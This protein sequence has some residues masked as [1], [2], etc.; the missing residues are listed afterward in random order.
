SLLGRWEEA[1]AAWK[2]Y[3]IRYPEHLI[4]HAFLA[5]D[6]SYLGDEVAARTEAAEVARPVALSPNSANGLL[7]RAFVLN[8]MGKPVDALV[9]ADHAKRLDPGDRDLYQY[10]RGRAYTLLGRWEEE[11]A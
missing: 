10:Q 3:L 11:I 8:S 7:W 6:Y 4:A 5:F 1:I 2:Q 9:A